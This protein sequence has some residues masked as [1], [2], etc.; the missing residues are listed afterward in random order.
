[1]RSGF[2]YSKLMPTFKFSKLVRDKIVEQQIASGA[3]PSYR[4]LSA[5]EHKQE[6]VRKIVE[7]AQ[8]IAQAGPEEVASEIADVQQALDDLKEKYGLTDEDIAKAGRVKN[9]KNGAFKQG[10]FVDYVA[11]DESNKWVAYYRKNA[12]RYPEIN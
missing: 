10:L 11:V 4:Q 7:E 9:D 6:L 12:D 1:M 5:A 3:K 8:E 2:C